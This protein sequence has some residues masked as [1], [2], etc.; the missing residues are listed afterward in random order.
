M[1]GKVM[2]AMVTPFKGD[3]VNFKEA[4]RLAQFL[5][6]NGSDSMLPLW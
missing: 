5:E 6:K 3:Q 2:T 1:F 4:Q